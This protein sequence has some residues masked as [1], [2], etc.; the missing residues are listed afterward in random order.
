MHGH[1]FFICPTDHLEPLINGFFKQDNFF[2]TSL[3]NSYTFKI[4]EVG[5]IKESIIK[6][7]IQEI[8]F[9]LS[10][11]NWIISDAIERQAFSEISVLNNFY[12]SVNKQKENYELLIDTQ[13][14]QYLM[15]VYHLQHKIQELKDG[16][17]SLFINNI[18]INGKIYLRKEEA[19]T[20]IPFDLLCLEYFNLN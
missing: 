20:D 11:D 13:N 8:S 16:L 14:K 7:N 18:K 6:N 10:E 2:C 4:L 1:L 9:I 3:C 15:I 5:Q 12:C 19:F 17:Q